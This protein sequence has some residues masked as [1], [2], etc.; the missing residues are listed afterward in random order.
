MK[1]FALSFIL[2]CSAYNLFAQYEDFGFQRD[3]S[4]IV[5]D[6]LVNNLNDP[7]GGG[8]NSCQFSSVDLN[9]N[10]IKDLFVYDRNSNRI[11][12]FI[13]NGTTDSIDYT[14]APQY[15]DKFPPIHDWVYFVDY[16]GDGKEDIFTYSYGGITVYK[17]ISNVTDGLKFSLITKTINSLQGTYYT[18]LYVSTVDRPAIADIDNDGDMDIISKWILGTYYQYHKNLSMELY[19]VPDSLDFVEQESCW[20]KFS[21]SSGSNKIFLGI[22]STMCPP[23]AK[24]DTLN[25]FSNGVK[26]AGGTILAADLNGDG[27]KDLLLSDIGYPNLKKLT[28]GGT[29]TNANM[30]SQDTLFPSNS[31]SV[32]LLSMPSPYLLDVNNDGKKDMIVSPFDGGH[33][34]SE[35][36]KSCWLYKNTGTNSSPVFEYIRNNFL[37]GDMID[38][39]S[40]AYPVLADYDGDGLLDLFIGNFGRRDSSYFNSSASL[41]SIY[42]AK[43]ALYKNIGT[44]AIPAFQFVTNDFAN[45][46]SRKL[47]GVV[48]TFGDI[49]GDGVPEMIIG[50]GDGWL[51][52]YNNTAATGSPMNMVLAQTHYMGIH[53]GHPFSQN[54]PMSTPQ[55]V[56]LDGDSLLDLV[57]GERNGNIEF[58]KNTGSKTI[59]NFSLFNDT[60]GGINVTKHAISNYGYSVPCFFKDST[61][62]FKLFT[63]SES[64]YIYYYKDIENHLASGQ[65]FTFVDSMYLYINEGSRSGLAVANLN[66]DLFPDLIIG[67]YSGGVSFFKGITPPPVSI[68]EYE[69]P[70]YVHMQA[71]P[72]PADDRLSIIPDNNFTLEKITVKIYNIVGESVLCGISSIPSGISIDTR[73]LKNG[74]YCYAIE[75]YGKFSDKEFFASG[76]FTVQH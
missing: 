73:N 19:G 72:I 50:N 41:V 70:S 66:N 10:G 25:S 11:L 64:G 24:S 23:L 16:D 45:I 15:R 20:G 55:L 9:Q 61:G 57:V 48:P 32:N 30:I 14:Y 27:V 35:N 62:H 59:P 38:V 43:I 22:D 34:V 69:Q 52:L 56:D 76:K 44:A 7:W 6:S 46:Y 74:L 3:L 58:Y 8:L 51:D 33:D 39:G 26:H 54:N 63:G 49:N 2:L 67:N 60:L 18:N 40:G 28:N 17:N 47:I 37:Q 53:V 71:Y 13:N 12:T 4:V 68:F 42:R 5:K 65:N 21:E 29:L 1:K 31:L 36:I 75:G